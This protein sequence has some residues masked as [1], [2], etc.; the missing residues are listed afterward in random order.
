MEII[1]SYIIPILGFV[2]IAVC[3]N[4]IAKLFGRIDLPLITGLLATGI[5]A[6]PYV[7]EFVDTTGVSKLKFIKDIALASIAFA[8]GAELYLKEFRSR[9]PSVSKN[10]FVQLFVIFGV[11]AFLVFQVMNFTDL[12]AELSRSQKIAVSILAGT[13][14]VAR[15]PSSAIAVI[16]ELRAKGPFTQTVLGVIVVI[17]VLVI[18]LFTIT[19]ALAKNLET[20]IGFQYSLLLI[21]AMELL[22]SVGLGYVMS[23]ILT[24]LLSVRLTSE[25]KSVLVIAIGWSAYLISYV[26]EDYSFLYLGK[27]LYLEPLLICIVA[28][29]IVSNSSKTRLEFLKIIKETSG[30]IYIG[31]FTVVGLSLSIDVLL[32]SWYFALIFFI[33]RIVSVFIGSYSGGIVAKDP[34]SFRNYGWVAHMTQAGVALG[35]TARLT[36]GIGPWGAGLSTILIAVIVLN[37]VI[38]PPLFKWA[39]VKI[40]EGKKAATTLTFDGVKDAIIFGLEN[41]S[42]ALANQLRENGWEVIIATKKKDFT[43]Y[44]VGDLDVR[45]FDEISEEE[46]QKVEIKKADALVCL[47]TDYE[48][49]RICE[50]ALEKIGIK[51]FVVRLSDRN[52]LERFHQIGAKIVDPST[53]IV[54]LLDHFVRSPLATSILL[55]MEEGQDSMDI[56][57]KNSELHGLALRDLRLPTEV[58][59]LSIRR[60]G[61]M[62]ISHGYTRLRKGDII[63]LVGSK[64]SLEEVSLKFE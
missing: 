37:D 10:S 42:I 26:V 53:A 41:Q 44:N 60:G 46:L 16:N 64:E 55:G 40:G 49:Y 2:L 61:Q 30:Y 7:L 11:G 33:V 43:E 31:L 15:S 58:I 45:H 27:K 62:L 21:L 5:I 9:L 19:V 13:I 50:L 29:L 56:E 6:G 23:L 14:F 25:F 39:L 24:K 48:N 4:Q 20:G 3:A 17:D 22:V 57:V 35:L 38:G 54:S 18:V 8:A 52:N 59:V 1:I 51:K 47:L 28:S 36:E 12:F 32:N 34:V 63:T